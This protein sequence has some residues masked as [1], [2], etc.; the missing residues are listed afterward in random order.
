[1][2]RA[3]FLDRDGVLIENRSDYVRE[4]SH[5]QILPKA[6]DALAGFRHDGF[7]IVVV[8]NQAAVGRGLMTFDAAQ[9]INDRLIKTIK[10]NSG[11]VDGIYMCPHKPEDQCTCR[12]PQ[13]GL[14]LQAARELSLDLQSSWMIGDAW[15]DLLAGQAAGLRGTVMVRT[16]R[17]SAQLM[18]TQPE[19]LKSFL[20]SDDLFDAFQ[21]IVQLQKSGS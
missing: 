3:V 8:T 14:L 9:E 2:F 21:T 16:G 17:G 6:L 19:D 18:E 4:W 20:V 5:V 7:K 10:A 13:P 1:M 15:S 11:W 12:K